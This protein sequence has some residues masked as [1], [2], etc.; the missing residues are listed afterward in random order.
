MNNLIAFVNQFLEYLIV[1]V[2]SIIAILGGCFIGI[3]CRKSK[4][5]KQLAAVDEQIDSKVE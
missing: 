3:K 1:F 4:D 5:L 2:V